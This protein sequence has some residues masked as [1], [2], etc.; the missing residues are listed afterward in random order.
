VTFSTY[1][2]IRALED[3]L[4]KIIVLDELKALRTAYGIKTFG[5]VIMPDHIHLVL[6]PPNGIELGRIIGQLKSRCARRYFASR[7]DLPKDKTKI[8]WLKRCYDHNCRNL[9]AVVEK[10]T[11]CH[12]NPS[13]AGLVSEPGRWKWSSFGW[14]EGRRDGPLEIDAIEM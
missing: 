9:Q 1:K 14:Y 13:Q 8:L 12:N 11:Y 7:T 5:Y 6:L 3:D 2:W 10:I 4:L